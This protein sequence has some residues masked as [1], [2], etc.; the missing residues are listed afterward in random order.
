MLIAALILT[1]FICLM[2]G[3][4]VAIALAASALLFAGIGF[5]FD[6][7]DNAFL[8]AVPDRLFGVV[9]N[10]TLLAIPLFIFMGVAL[11]KSGISEALLSQLAEQLRKIKGGLAFSVLIV[12]A[13]LAASTGIV[14]ATVVTLGLIALPSLL[15]QG[16]DEKLATGLVCATGTLGQIIPPSIVLIILSDVI[17]NSYQ[18]A[19]LAQGIFSPETVTVADL[20][21]GALI[22]GILLILMYGIYLFI[23]VSKAHVAQQSN[24]S[25]DSES[26]ESA[27]SLWIIVAPILLI[28]LVLGAI[29][30]GFATPTEAAAIGAGGALLLV[31]L[32][33]KLTWSVLNKTLIDSSQM[34]GMV[35]LILMGATI[36]ALVFR[37]LGGDEMVEAFFKTLP[38]GQWTALLLVMLV[39]F[40][41][42][43]ILDFIEI[44]FIVI[45]IVAPPLLQM[46]IDPVWLGVLIALNLQTSFLTP[47][48]GFS[49]FYLRG[50]LP[51]HI[52]TSTLYSG[53]IPFI[54]IQLLLIAIVMLIPSL[55][56]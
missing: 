41:L 23:K 53:V 13:L 50:V 9:T 19:Q 35:F 55:V 5:C 6:V 21:M 54:A 30:L 44:T 34:T 15:K 47:P 52:K 22:P 1:T 12:S 48:F 3:Y 46:G 27:S 31:I 4:P 14:G 51:Q 11:E 33:K 39:V 42:G 24:L 49:L 18:E 32:N 26:S 17:S 36:F 45:P 8:M 25:I 2:T 56:R 7:F 28:V 20:F 40:I 10:E 43:F 16:Y 29:L 37:G 38:G